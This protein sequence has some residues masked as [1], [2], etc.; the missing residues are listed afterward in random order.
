[1]NVLIRNGV[2]NMTK[3]PES[4]GGGKSG[5]SSSDNSVRGG[6]STPETPKERRGSG[7]T[8]GKSTG[9]GSGFFSFIASLLRGKPTK[10]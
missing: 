5:K 2:K 7:A 6:K 10:Q 3:R 8:G 4:E 1:M 9:E